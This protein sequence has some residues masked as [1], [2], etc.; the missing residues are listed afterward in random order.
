LG[1]CSAKSARA[2]NDV[3]IARKPVDA[4]QGI[5]NTLI[6]RSRS[7]DRCPAV[8]EFIVAMSLMG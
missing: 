7:G 5:R 3:E 2:L 8:Q 6:R 4:L 1:P